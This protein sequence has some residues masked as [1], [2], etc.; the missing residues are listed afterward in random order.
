MDICHFI[1]IHQL[2]M[3]FDSKHKLLS[4]YYQLDYNAKIAMVHKLDLN[5]G[6]TVCKYIFTYLHTYI[7]QM[8]R[9]TLMR[10]FVL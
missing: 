9:Y 3:L 8:L 6:Y 5:Q 10:R 4:L 7:F 2:K 1:D